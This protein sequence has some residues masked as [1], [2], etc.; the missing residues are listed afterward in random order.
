MVEWLSEAPVEWAVWRLVG[1]GAM[2]GRAALG[3]RMRFV[4]WV[5][6]Y[7]DWYANPILR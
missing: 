5:N 7:A 1:Q 4:R 6:I 2:L 3:G